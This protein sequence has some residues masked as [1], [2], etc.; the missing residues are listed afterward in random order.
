MKKSILSI[1]SFFIMLQISA[2]T[3]RAISMYL[4]LHSAKVIYDRVNTGNGAGL[5]IEFMLN[6]KG[7]VKP[8]MEFDYDLFGGTDIIKLNRE[9]QELFQKYKVPCVFIGVFY[10]PIN[11]VNLSFN[12]GTSFFNSMTYFAV[13][14]SIVIYFDKKQRFEGKV[15][16]TNIFQRDIAGKEPFGYLSFGIGIKLF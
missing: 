3:E 13:K 5:G 15:S 7:E 1:I 4:S 8:K 11:R 12:L 16:L 6:T 9:G 14:P 2:Q 10:N